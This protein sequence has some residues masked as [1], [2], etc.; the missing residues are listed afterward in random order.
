M[1][2]YDYPQA[3]VLQIR[4]LQASRDVADVGKIK[5]VIGF[6]EASVELRNGTGGTT[7]LARVAAVEASGG[8]GGGAADVRSHL[9]AFVTNVSGP[10]PVALHPYAGVERDGHK[11][12]TPFGTYT[13][14]ASSSLL[15]SPSAVFQPNLGNWTTSSA[16]MTSR[17]ITLGLRRLTQVTLGLSLA[18]GS[19][20][21][22]HLLRRS[23]CSHNAK[24]D[25]VDGAD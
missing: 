10:S 5:N 24:S 17:N 6:D 13:A 3:I 23:N 2:M 11:L 9:G 12:D 21:S 22:C 25:S 15:S 4:I 16:T 8:G 1:K 18:N 7:L 20:F 19:S 14:A